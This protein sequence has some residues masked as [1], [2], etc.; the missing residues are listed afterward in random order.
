MQIRGSTDNA[1]LFVIIKVGILRLRLIFLH[2]LKINKGFI[3]TSTSALY[4]DWYLPVYI[5]PLK[6]DLSVFSTGCL[7]CPGSA[8]TSNFC[9]LLPSHPL[10]SVFSLPVFWF[11][12]PDNL[13]SSSEQLTVYRH[14]WAVGTLFS[15]WSDSGELPFII[16]EPFYFHCWFL[17]KV[18]T[19]VLSFICAWRWGHEEDWEMWNGGLLW[20]LEHSGHLK[21]PETDL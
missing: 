8:S 19:F 18:G 1:V 2:R 4:Q 11:W 6:N 3:W 12:P 9:T 16:S 17:F 21:L 20:S 5:E 10:P 7:Y 14:H 15:F 13:H